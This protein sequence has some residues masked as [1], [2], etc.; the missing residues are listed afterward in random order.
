MKGMAAFPPN[1]GT[2]VSGEFDSGR[3][4]LEGGLTDDADVVF[5]EVGSP[6]P[7]G[8]GVDSFDF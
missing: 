6:C 3:H 7:F 2:F 1:D 8:Y 4:P 5:G